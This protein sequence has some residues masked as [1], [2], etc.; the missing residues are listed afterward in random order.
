MRFN[1][2]DELV[3]NAGSGGGRRLAF[4]VVNVIRIG[5]H[6]SCLYHELECKLADLVPS[7][8][9]VIS[10]NALLRLAPPSV[11]GSLQ[12]GQ[13]LFESSHD[14]IHYSSASY[15]LANGESSLPG[16]KMNVHMG[17]S[18]VR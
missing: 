10:S 2:S 7:Q 5:L 16:S 4:V 1:E 12:L 11:A 3:L 9:S 18:R 14:R 6:I 13:T 17:C 15:L 8:A